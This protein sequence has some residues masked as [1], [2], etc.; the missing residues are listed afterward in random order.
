[1]KLQKVLRK[2]F[3][4]KTVVPSPKDMRLMEIDEE[5]SEIDIR[6]DGLTNARFHRKEMIRMS[7]RKA[8]LIEEGTGLDSWKNQASPAYRQI[9]NEE[10][11][12]LTEESLNLDARKNRLLSERQ[13]KE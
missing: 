4:K 5:L 6:L 9:M 11:D 3:T 1:M 8:E 2:L 12:K 10:Y 7:L 13:A